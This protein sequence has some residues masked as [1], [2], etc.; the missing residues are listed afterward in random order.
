MSGVA[1]GKNSPGL[2]GLTMFGFFLVGG[3]CWGLGWLQ[4]TERVRREQMPVSYSEAAKAD[5]QKSC[6]GGAPSALFDCVFEKA[7]ASQ[8]QALAEQDLSAQQ[9]AATSALFSALLAFA[10]LI[11]TSVGVWFVK[12]TLDATLIAVEDT[13]AATEAMRE[14]NAIARSGQRPILV[15]EDIGFEPWIEGSL[16]SSGVDMALCFANFKNIGPMPAMTVSC[17]IQRAYTSGNPTS[18]H[19]DH[20]LNTPGMR[21]LQPHVVPSGNSH[22]SPGIAINSLDLGQG[23]AFAAAYFGPRRFMLLVITVRYRSAI[24]ES[25]I[26]ETRKVFAGSSANPLNEPLL[27]REW[28]EAPIVGSVNAL[29]MT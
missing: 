12:R 14:A 19:V 13:S 29:E 16:A 27:T 5:A 24:G 10:A 23:S 4:A 2:T 9:R 20:L 28:L 8:E 26:W 6:A 17:S 18:E 3:L 21:D 15:F 25:E 7:Q 11:V 1:N 22:R